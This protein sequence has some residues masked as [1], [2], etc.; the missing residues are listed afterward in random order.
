VEKA[1]TGPGFGPR[2]AFQATLGSACAAV[3]SEEMTEAELA[4]GLLLLRVPRER[5]GR[6]AVR[7]E[8]RR[9]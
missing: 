4:G 1:D 3:V 9:G 8:E 7:L 5:F 2:G 6:P